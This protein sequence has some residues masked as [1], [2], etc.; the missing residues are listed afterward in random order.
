M[1]PL[2]ALLWANLPFDDAGRDKRRCR[3]WAAGLAGA[4][5]GICCYGY[6]AVR[7]FLPVFLTTAVLVTWRGWWDRLRTRNGAL[8][9]GA[10]AVAVSVTF[11]PLAW[12]HLTDTNHTGISKRSVATWVWR[13][14]DPVGAKIGAALA[15]YPGHFGPDFLF[16]NGDHY[17]IQSVPG[18]GQFHWYMA[19]LMVLGLIVVLRRA[20]VSRAARVLLIWLPLYP[21]SD[22]LTQHISAQHVSMHALRASPGMCVLI[23]LAAVGL[24][25]A[26]A[27]FWRRQRGPA[28]AAG[29]LAAVVAVAL[30]VRFLHY[31][32]GDY[33]RLEETYYLGWHVDLLEACEWLRPRLDDVDA[34]FCTT[35]GMNLPHIVALVGLSYDPHEWFRG[36]RD[37]R[38]IGQWDRYVRYG[39]MTFMYGGPLARLCSQ[40]LNEL[41]TNGR[42]DRVLFIVRPGKTPSQRL[43]HQVT[44]LGGLVSLCIYEA[45]I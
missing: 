44:G 7:V 17:N 39:K 28:L 5:T 10:L 15:R 30:N 37:V 8:A 1:T 16:I 3:I 4:L 43:L 34:V 24:V 45:T 26:A 18:F 19:P 36:P 22:C 29:A 13:P 38:T 23:L 35:Q 41:K 33:N 11:G 32:F 14:D 20:V 2:A 9:I 31:F 21:V 6:P 42:A 12:Q 27:W 25:D 40:R